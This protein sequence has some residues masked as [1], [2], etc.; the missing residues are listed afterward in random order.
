MDVRIAE[1]GL[2]GS[3]DFP[4]VAP[5]SLNSPF[6]MTL[7]EMPSGRCIEPESPHR[8]R[9]RPRVEGANRTTQAIMQRWQFQ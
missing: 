1:Y 8:G 6:E 2:W 5:E 9:F 7:L 3:V 4:C